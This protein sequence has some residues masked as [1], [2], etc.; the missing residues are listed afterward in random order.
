MGARYIRGTDQEGIQVRHVDVA[1]RRRRGTG[2]RMTAI[3]EPGND[4]SLLEH[5]NQVATGRRV[6]VRVV[7]MFTTIRPAS[8]EQQP[9]CGWGRPACLGRSKTG[10]PPPRDRFGRGAWSTIVPR[11]P[12]LVVKAGDFV[13]W[14]DLPRDATV[15]AILIQRKGLLTRDIRVVEPLGRIARV[16]VHI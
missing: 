8:L 14:V 15:A 13:L 1:E 9:V 2:P 11:T 10:E 3:H 12:L 7:V 16:L 4:A 5:A 6:L